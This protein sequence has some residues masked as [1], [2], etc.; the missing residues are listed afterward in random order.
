MV[1]WP[2]PNASARPC[3]HAHRPCRLLCLRG[4]RCHPASDACGY[5]PDRRRRPRDF[6][7]PVPLRRGGRLL[8]A[9]TLLGTTGTFDFADA[10]IWIGIAPLIIDRYFVAGSA[11]L[12]AALRVPSTAP[13]WFPVWRAE[14]RRRLDIVSCA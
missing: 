1:S 10:S 9:R 2:R 12:P 5:R 11:Y 7:G 6:D 13:S 14:G 8:V 3:G 4:A